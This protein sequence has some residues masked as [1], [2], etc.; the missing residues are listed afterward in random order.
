MAELKTKQTTA[1]VAVFLKTVAN[2]QSRRDCRELVKLMKQ[3]TRKPPK[4]WGT[5]IVGFGTCHLK[6]A[7]GRELEWPLVA[8]APRKVSLSLYLTC[9]LSQYN[10]L[11]KKLGKHKAGKGCLYIKT[12]DDVD[13]TVLKQFIQ[14]AVAD[15]KQ[16]TKKMSTK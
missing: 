3:A 1:S 7:S 13:R 8:F 15:A 10:G 9:D 5:S 14:I 12:L 6:Y 11:L 16:L 4:M 2:E